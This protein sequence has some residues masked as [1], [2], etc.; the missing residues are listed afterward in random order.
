MKETLQ[1]IK[2]SLVQAFDQPETVNLDQSIQQLQSF[3]EQ[4]GDKGTMIEDTITALIQAKH[5]TVQL[6]SAGDV[7]S[8]AAFGQAFNALEHAIKSFEQVDN[9][10]V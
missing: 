4:Y 1:R 10:P 7:S 5:A 6:Q 9:D 8:S 3:K 2:E